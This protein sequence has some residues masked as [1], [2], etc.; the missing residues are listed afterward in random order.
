MGSCQ[1]CFSRI[2]LAE[3]HNGYPDRLCS[4]PAV[5]GCR[6]EGRSMGPMTTVAPVTDLLRP[7]RR[8]Q[9]SRHLQRAAP[10]PL[11]AAPGQ[12]EPRWLG[13]NVPQPPPEIVALYDR[14]RPTEEP[15]RDTKGGRYEAQVEWPQFRAPAYLTRFMLSRGPPCRYGLLSDKPWPRPHLPS[16]GHASPRGCASYGFGSGSRACRR[17]RGQSIAWLDPAAGICP[18]HACAALRGCKRWRWSRESDK[19]SG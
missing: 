4:I 1:V 19:R 11:A 5:D 9:L 17:Q 13:A 15:R 8:F 16:T 12:P 14:H 18:C 10:T 2:A 7:F 6:V 3:I